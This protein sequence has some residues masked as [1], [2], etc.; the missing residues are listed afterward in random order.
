MR[1]GRD[2]INVITT[3]RREA[4]MEL[5]DTQTSQSAFQANVSQG[6]SASASSSMTAASSSASHDEMA[7]SGLGTSSST[8]SSASSAT[9]I[10]TR[11]SHADGEAHRSSTGTS[12][13][14]SLMERLHQRF[15]H[16]QELWQMA[17][18]MIK[19]LESQR[20]SLSPYRI[21]QITA[22]FPEGVAG[23]TVGQLSNRYLVKQ[24]SGAF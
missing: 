9:G 15:L 3:P 6:E 1:D 23:A 16:L 14:D 13:M 11:T 17:N 12:G 21:T 24:P 19:W 20:L 5:T 8:G 18:E 7:G 4:H 2:E 10:A 22:E